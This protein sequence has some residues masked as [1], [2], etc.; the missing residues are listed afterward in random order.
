MKERSNPLKCK[1][2][3]NVLWNIYKNPLSLSEL[4]TV[5]RISPSA[6]YSTVIPQMLQLGL[7]EITYAEGLHGSVKKMVNITD[8]GRKLLEVLMVTEGVQQ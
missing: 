4:Q 6:L 3:I 2:V 7:I 1:H 5:T 8:K